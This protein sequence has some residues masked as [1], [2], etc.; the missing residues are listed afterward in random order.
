MIIVD[1]IITPSQ[2]QWA[3][4]VAGCR[5]PFNSWHKSDSKWGESEYYI[6]EQDYTLMKRLAHAGDDHGKFM[7]MLPV[8]MDIT[9]PLY[10]WKQMDQ[11]KVGTVT[12]STS[13]MH[14]LLADP[15]T[16]DDFSFDHTPMYVQDNILAHLNTLRGQY[17]AEKD[18]DKKVEIFAEANEFL[19]Q[20]FMQLRTWSGNYQVLRHIYHARKDHKLGDWHKF[21]EKLETLPYS[22]LI[23]GE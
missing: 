12:D 11:Y 3:T 21:C 17:L 9:A 14:R 18:P 10:W 20:S 5:N 6:G 16:V 23:T 7:R 4:V 8:I 15:F 2:Y 13:T 22:E 1:N 19:P